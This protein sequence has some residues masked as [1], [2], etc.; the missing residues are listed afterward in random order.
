LSPARRTEL[1]RALAVPRPKRPALHPNLAEVY[2]RKI[3]NL[4]R[5]LSS[6]DAPEAL[7]TSRELIDKVIIL[8]P[9]DD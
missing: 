5:A 7:E 2:R 1:T 3:D 4:Q 6:A 9:T 8:P